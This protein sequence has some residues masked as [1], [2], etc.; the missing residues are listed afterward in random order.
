MFPLWIS[1]RRLLVSIIANF[2]SSSKLWQ[3]SPKNFREGDIISG[4]D[5]FGSVRENDL[6]VDHRIMC[7]PNVYGQVVKVYGTETDKQVSSSPSYLPLRKNVNL[8]GTPLSGNV[9]SG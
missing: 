1:E 4:G 6:M 8:L 7:P 9:Y 2:Y 3:Y 5:I